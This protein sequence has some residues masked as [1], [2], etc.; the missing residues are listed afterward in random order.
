MRGAL[1]RA[2]EAGE[3][4]AEQRAEWRRAYNRALR[5]RADLSGARRNQLS[6][7]IETL[8][9]IARSDQLDASRMPALFLQ[10][11]RNTEYWPGRPYPVSGQRIS[12]AGSSLIF[13]Y[14]PGQGL[15]IQ[16]LANFGRANGLWRA[17]R[18]ERLRDLLDE[19]VVIA[20]QRG[21]SRRGSTGS[22]SA[23]ARRPG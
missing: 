17:G 11:Q 8:E 14:Y 3:I 4:T 1:R 10:L 7:V 6:S 9:A 2:L 20:S 19:L 15:Q 18:E 5:T 23:G 22:G 12:F 13:Q 16:P 21:T